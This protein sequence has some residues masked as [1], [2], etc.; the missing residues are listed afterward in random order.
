MKDKFIKLLL[1]W[2]PLCLMFPV[3]AHAALSFVGPLDPANGFPRWYKDSRGVRLALCL[4]QNTFCQPLDG[5]DPALPIS[6]PTNFADES[7]WW[8][9]EALIDNVE[10]GQV[11]LVMAIEGGFA[12]GVPLAGDR[13]AFSRLRIRARDV[14]LGTYR[15]THP[16]GQA[17]FE[18]TSPIGRQINDTN[19][20]GVQVESFDGALAG[21]VGPFL[22]WNPAVAPAA[23]AGFVGDPLV[24]HRVIGSPNGTN[25]LRVE[26]RINGTFTE[27]GFTNEFRISGKL[28]TLPEEPILSISPKGGIFGTAPMVNIT[29]SIPSTIFYTLDASDPLT[30]PTRL[31]YTA[32]FQLADC[33]AIKFAA[34]TPNAQSDV[35]TELYIKAP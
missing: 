35:K 22:V 17:I 33:A 10:G 31:I 14:P 29:S 7:F 3:L 2:L 13:I 11:L 23:P 8:T 4:D 27:V 9:G 24:P 18:A 15:I 28:D 1:G 34:T 5:A 25:F 32:P 6:F 21:Q 30:S 12:G 20:V 16:Y 19:D 26:R